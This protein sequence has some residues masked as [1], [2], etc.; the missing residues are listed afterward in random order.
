MAA[1]LPTMGRQKKERRQMSKRSSPLALRPGWTAAAVVAALLLA[2]C[3]PQ[4]SPPQQ[5]Q[6][7]NPSVTYKYRGD[8]ELLQANQNAI[9]FCSQYH[10]SAQTVSITETQEG[11]KVIVF[12]CS[13]QVSAPV[14]M[15]L[16]SSDL[17]YRFR[18]DQDLL[19][20]S[21]NADIYCI[22]H[23]SQRALSTGLA[24]TNG[25]KTASFQCSSN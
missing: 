9:N 20:A 6:A 12:E 24:T 19:E 1:P 15:E 7:S 18:T 23:G 11:S 3:V 13:A 5:I 14:P 25:S 10:A 8:Q 2:A 21:R 4:H 22:N 17:S 16:Y